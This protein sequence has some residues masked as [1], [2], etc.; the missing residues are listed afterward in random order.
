MGS[1]SNYLELRLL[2]HVLGAG[3]VTTPGTVYFALFS[4]LPSDTGGG[5][6]L[7]AGTA[8]GY[9]RLAVTNNTTNFPAATTNGT[10]GKGE[11]SLA[12]AQ[13]FAANGGAGNWPTVL[14]WALMDAST[15]GNQ[16][17]W[18][19]VAALAIIPAAQ[20]VIP[21]GTVLWRED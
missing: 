12:V 14:G 11:K 2:D 20:F 16:L 8:N 6:E 21:A 9:V 3:T 17:L 18:G 19:E 1:K 10:T 4:A 15:G 5:T 13:S 7:T